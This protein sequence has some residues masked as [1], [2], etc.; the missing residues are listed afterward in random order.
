MFDWEYYS[1]IEI[2]TILFLFSGNFMNMCFL[3]VVVFSNGSSKSL[4]TIKFSTLISS[5]CCY[6]KFY[7]RFQYV[8][9]RA[10]N[11]HIIMNIKSIEMLWYVVSYA[12]QLLWLIYLFLFSYLTITKK[13]GV[14]LYCI[15]TWI[16]CFSLIISGGFS[17]LGKGYDGW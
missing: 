17:I 11:K 7:L 5:S 4:K 1:V 9:S 14:I 2:V 8:Y 6:S 16:Y 15:L 13:I 10:W 12:G 3:L